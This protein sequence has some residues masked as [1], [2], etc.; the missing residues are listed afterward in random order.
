[1]NYRPDP[2]IHAPL[3][4]AAAPVVYKILRK[5]KEIIDPNMIMHPG[6][7]AWIKGVDDPLAIPNFIVGYKKSEKQEA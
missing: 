2:T 3:T 4:Y 1:V 7:L 5:I 6:R